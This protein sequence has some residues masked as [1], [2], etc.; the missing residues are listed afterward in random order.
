MSRKILKQ[1]IEF[2]H[3]NVVFL[4]TCFLWFC[5]STDS[6][7]SGKQLD[8]LKKVSKTYAKQKANTQRDTLLIKSIL[9]IAYHYN[10]IRL[11]SSKFYIDSAQRFCETIK[12]QKGFGFISRVRGHYFFRIGLYDKSIKELMAALKIAEQYHDKTLEASINI[13]I[14]T[15]YVY[16]NLYEKAKKY[17]I[18][19]SELYKTSG[20]ETMFGVALANIGNSELKQGR[21]L[22]A[23][24]YFRKS[25]AITQK[26]T[27][28]LRNSR[29]VSSYNLLA[30]AYLNAGMDDSSKVCEQ[31]C[32]TLGSAIKNHQNIYDMYAGFSKYYLQRND[33]EKSISY[34]EKAL[35]YANQLASIEKKSGLYKLLYENYK[36][37]NQTPNALYFL[38]KH[39]VLED[40]IVRVNLSKQIASLDLQVESDLQKTQIQQLAIEKLTQNRNYLYF[41]LFISLLS[42]ALFL[43]FNYQLK[44]K[45]RSLLGKNKE[46]SEAMLKGQTTERKRV[47]SD[48]HDNLGS[49]MSSIR[50]AFQSIDTTKWTDNEKEVFSNVQVMFDKAYDDIRLLSHNLLP[51]EFERFGLTKTLQNFI[52]KININTPINFNLTISEGFKRMDNRVEFEL[53]SICLELVNNIMKHSK[54]TEAKIELYQIKNQIKLIISDNG[55]GIF[56]NDSDGKGMKNVQARVDSLNGTWKIQNIENEGFV[57]EILISV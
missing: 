2:T 12:W 42:I 30:V 34:A 18:R 46:I 25:L 14:G 20:N 55:I 38:E 4:L 57:N 17:F 19:G 27:A 45:N 9:E 23:I 41:I 51:E 49:T 50:W 3:L 15:L 24:A 31:R 43:F 56:N 40:S 26:S 7:A 48:L 44:A 29:I 53:Y 39:K 1:S 33:A 47:A 11:D 5:C 52:R 8:S 35:F 32:V 10:D 16:N 28:A 6:V 21:Y 37:L 54:A 36:K 13:H 22:S